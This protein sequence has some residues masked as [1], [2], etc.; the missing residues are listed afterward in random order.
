[1]SKVKQIKSKAWYKNH[2][3]FLY[4]A[5]KRSNNSVHSWL[6]LIFEY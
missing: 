2:F 5:L 6:F 4:Q 3:G 1:M